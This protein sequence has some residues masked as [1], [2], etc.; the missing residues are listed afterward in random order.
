M[1]LA[2]LTRCVVSGLELSSWYLSLAEET[3][4]NPASSASSC[5]T[6]ARISLN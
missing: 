4:L 5:S 2:H 1:Q 3:Y 6:A